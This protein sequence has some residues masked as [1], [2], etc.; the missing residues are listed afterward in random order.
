MSGGRAVVA[1]ESARAGRAGRGAVA[2]RS[3]F[4][5]DRGRPA[6]LCR[7]E[8][9]GPDAPA[10]VR[11]LV[12]EAR[13]MRGRDLWP[14]VVITAAPISF[15]VLGSWLATGGD[16]RVIAVGI[17]AGWGCSM[18]MSL[19]VYRV[20]WARR[21]TRAA[22][23]ACLGADV[24]PA[25]GYSLRALSAEADGCRVCPECAAAWR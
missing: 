7:A 17:G 24:C 20:F 2:R 23:E 5:D 18:V 19:V 22:R 15:S 25:C 21:A 10:A 12:R 9:V 8:D 6:G 3:S 1:G 11:R 14:T 4:V 13:V 16:V